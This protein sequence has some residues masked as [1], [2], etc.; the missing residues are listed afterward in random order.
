MGTSQPSEQ[1]FALSGKGVEAKAVRSNEGLVVFEGAGFS[2]VEATSLSGGNKKLRVQL[3]NEGVVGSV[4]GALRF[5]KSH[6]FSSPSQAASVILGTPT[7]GR[8]AWKTDTGQSIADIEEFG[9]G[10]I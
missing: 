5:L 7:N 1:V 10:G 6:I 8:Q 2:Q 4:Q 3:Q 9:A